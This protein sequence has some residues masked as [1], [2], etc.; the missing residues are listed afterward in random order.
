M[1]NLLHDTRYAAR[2][3]ARRPGFSA[4]AVITL[5]LGIAAA[6][7]VYGA[8]LEVLEDP[9]LAEKL[10]SGAREAALPLAAHVLGRRLIGLYRA[11]LAGD[12]VA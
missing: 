8:A 4:L 7:A 12:E 11:L 3:L 2:A 10:G 9:G 6:T 5:A 1:S